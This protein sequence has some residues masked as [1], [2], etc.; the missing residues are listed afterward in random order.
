[1]ARHEIR[2]V[3]IAA[4]K[5]LPFEPLL[6]RVIDEGFPSSQFEQGRFSWDSLRSGE[7]LTKS[8]REGLTRVNQYQS[9]SRYVVA[10]PVRLRHAGLDPASRGGEA[11]GPGFLLAQE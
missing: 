10:A 6:P 4:E 7:V 1:M 9:V 8:V 2:R 5:R 3:T 11:G